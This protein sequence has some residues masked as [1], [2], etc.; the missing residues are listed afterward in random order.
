MSS[1]RQ[2]CLD[3]VVVF[4]LKVWNEEEEFDHPMEDPLP[5]ELL[6]RKR[7]PLADKRLDTLSKQLDFVKIHCED[8]DNFR[9][10]LDYARGK[11]MNFSLLFVVNVCYQWLIKCVAHQI[12]AYR[13]S[14]SRGVQHH[15]YIC[16]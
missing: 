4:C 10:I 1:S 11:K 3:F 14:E 13:A 6:L 9:A 15:A 7:Y 5:M 16:I 12:S 8:P 2:V